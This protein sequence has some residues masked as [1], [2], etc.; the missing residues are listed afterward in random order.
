MTFIRQT[1]VESL[2]VLNLSKYAFVYDDHFAAVVPWWASSDLSGAGAGVLQ[3]GAVTNDKNIGV[4]GLYTGTATTGR[5]GLR[6]HVDGIQ[7]GANEW[8]FASRANVSNLS[9]ATNPFTVRFGF[10]DSAQADS[11]DGHY[12]RYT[13]SVNSGKWQAVTRINS[14]ETATDTGVTVAAMTNGDPMLRFSISVAGNG[15]EVIF[16]INDDQVA[17]HTP[18]GFTG[19]SRLTGIAYSIVKGNAG[20]TSRP[21]FIDYTYFACR[22]KEK[23]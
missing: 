16:K 15:A 23:R 14:V 9:D 6:S 12:F 10:M 2:L 20:T 7:F 19:S 8:Y 13:H 21:L 22:L 1:A 18:V 5:A 11:A 4:I 3:S 17:R